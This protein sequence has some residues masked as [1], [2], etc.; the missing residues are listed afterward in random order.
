MKKYLQTGGQ[1]LIGALL[2][3]FGMLVVLDMEIGFD[4]EPYAYPSN[5]L[6]LSAAAVCAVFSI[7]CYFRIRE[8]TKQ[9]LSG[10]EEDAAEGHMYRNYTDASLSSTLAMLFSLGALSLAIITT[11]PVWVLIAGIVFT[12]FSSVISMVLPGLVPH[13]YPDRD[14]PSIS[15]KHYAAKLLQSSDDGEKHVM[16]GGLYQTHL[17]MNSLLFAAILLLLFYSILSGTSQLF[18]IFIIIAILAVANAQYM[19]SIR[20]K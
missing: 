15:D 7:Y 2:G 20:N 3:F 1:L 11:Q 19:F 14:L 9:D 18:S 16:L 5:I 6:I 13:M 12:I 10:E 4:F 8:T 17:T